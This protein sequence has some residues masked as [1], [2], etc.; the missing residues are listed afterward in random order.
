MSVKNIKIYDYNQKLFSETQ[1]AH[2]KVVI[3]TQEKDSTRL[4]KTNNY[5]LHIHFNI[6]F[7]TQMYRLQTE[8]CECTVF[9]YF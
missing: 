5:A 6:I 7:K 2:F 9:N 1:M 8:L 3:M 4:V